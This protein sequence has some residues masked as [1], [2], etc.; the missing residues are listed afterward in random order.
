M[1]KTYNFYCDESTHLEFD[2]MPYLIISYV[3]C[4]S[5]KTKQHSH[6]I[7]EIKAKHKFYGEIKWSALS[8]SRLPFYRDII[9]Y[10]FDSELSFRSVIVEKGRIDK[11]RFSMTFDE[12]YYRMYY[13]LLY[14]KIDMSNTYNA[15]LDIKDTRS[16]KK[17]KKL[18]DILNVD[19][20]AICNMQSIKSYESLMMQ[21]CDVIMGAVN[22]SLRGKVG[23]KAK[24][25]LINLISE[26]SG[27]PLNQSTAKSHNKFNLFFLELQ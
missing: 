22:Y 15:Y 18:K 21:M 25:E 5:L 10:F 20:S 1:D 27:V 6:A 14:H 9:N 19:F 2:G 3:S 17:L 13:Q 24:L 16:A 11:E 12:F 8:S 4:E 26:R 23:V 7:K